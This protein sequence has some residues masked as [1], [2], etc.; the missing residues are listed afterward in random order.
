MKDWLSIGE[1]SKRTGFSVKALRIYEEKGL[2]VPHA[3]SENQYRVYNDQQLKLAGKIQ[4]FK[5]LG[6]SLEQIK[7]LLA[8]T[9]Q[10]SLKELLERR[11]QESRLASQVLSEQI[12]SLEAILTSL[13]SGHELTDLERSQ[14]MENFLE[15][16]I[17]KL[18]RR[19][20]MDQQV[21]EKL[22]DEVARFSPEIA[23]I[24]PELRKI[25][26]YAHKENILLGPGRGTSPAS[27]VLF[28]EGYSPINPLQFGLLPELFSRTKYLHLEVEYARYQEIGRMC[29]EL[30][31]QTSFDVVA[32][33]S[34]VLDIFADMKKKIGEV[35][36]DNFSD[37]DP[38]ILEAP[39]RTGVRGLYGVEWNSNYHAWQSMPESLKKNND[40]GAL[41]RWHTQNVI[42]SPEEFIT[43]AILHEKW[44][45]Q[46][47]ANFTTA[48]APEN[49]PELKNS[50][51][52]MVFREDWLKILMRLTGL[53]VLRAREVL[54]QISD[55]N[56]PPA[57]TVVDDIADESLKVLLK[58][59]APGVYAKSHAVTH[60]WYYKRTA[61]LKS[62]WT[63][64]Y[65]E[66]IDRWE[67]KHQTIWQEFGY[68][69]GDGSYYLKA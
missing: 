50:R 49:L 52:Y 35:Q 8:E 43:L 21:H 28:A 60:W 24:V 9:K 67:Q 46:D 2:L 25:R 26:E 23:R 65:L 33:R 6:F 18:K 19:G 17:D 59:T 58:K 16:S 3:R 14:V 66:V 45:A 22:S 44:S 32:F 38:M 5:Q 63:K 68:P 20:L 48:K 62:L 12:T 56:N 34:P 51:G 7:I 40:W 31:A 57:R 13:N 39:K 37:I 42:N 30:K 54:T 47:L 4:H 41:E 11:L 36:F 69:L 64:E 55:M 15:S 1:F 53:D 61:I 27:L 10:C 29:D